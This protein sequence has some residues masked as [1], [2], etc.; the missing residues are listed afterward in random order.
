MY[1]RRT[2]NTPGSTRVSRVQ[3]GV[4]PNCVTKNARCRQGENRIA[5]CQSALRG[6]LWR[7]KAAIGAYDFFYGNAE[8]GERPAFGGTDLPVGQRCSQLQKGRHAVGGTPTAAR[9]TRALL[10]TERW[11]APQYVTTNSPE[12]VTLEGLKHR[13]SPEYVAKKIMC[14]V[15][16][17][18]V[19]VE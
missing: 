1:G 12:C 8:S 5:G 6:G 17:R 16:G 9:G 14:E 11:R 15:M 2:V 10:G 3:F 13:D 7:I 19:V 4:P 18:I